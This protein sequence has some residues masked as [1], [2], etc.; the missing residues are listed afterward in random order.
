M[1]FRSAE[2]ASSDDDE[3]ELDVDENNIPI[4]K[5]ADGG[6]IRGIGRPFFKGK[7][8][9]KGAKDAALRSWYQ[10][11]IALKQDKKDE[12]LKRIAG[13]D[14]SIEEY[15][16]RLEA[17]GKTLTPEEKAKKR[18]AKLQAELAKAM[19]AAEG[20]DIEVEADEEA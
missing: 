12:L 4:W 6:L 19:E 18:I 15:T 5:T 14:T 16:E 8:I 9:P 17:I 11:N 10:Y 20:L 3:V 7:H 2:E 1:L 13:C